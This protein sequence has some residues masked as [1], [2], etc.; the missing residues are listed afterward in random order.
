[1]DPRNYLASL[2]CIEVQVADD[3]APSLHILYRCAMC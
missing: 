2:S 3:Y 1:M